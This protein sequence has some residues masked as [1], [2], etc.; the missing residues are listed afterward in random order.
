MDS[1]IFVN[2]KLGVYF[3]V[4]VDDPCAVGSKENL[5]YVFEELSKVMLLRYTDAV[6]VGETMKHLGDE[7]ERTE[8]AWIQR[9][10]KD[11]VRRTLA[12]MGMDK[13]NPSC[14]LGSNDKLTQSEQEE[15]TVELLLSAESA[16]GGVGVDAVAF[17]ETAASAASATM[18]GS[19]ATGVSLTGSGLAPLEAGATSSAFSILSSVCTRSRSTLTCSASCGLPA[20]CGRDQGF[21]VPKRVAADV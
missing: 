17:L 8:N 7:Y 14:V 21:R 6:T 13:C 18:R 1:Q 12:L 5:H 4:H 15:E 19:S 16:L 3:H 10:A 9:P 2:K 20:G 11:Y